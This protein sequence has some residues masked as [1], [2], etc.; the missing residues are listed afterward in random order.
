MAYSTFWEAY[1]AQ[2]PDSPYTPAG[3]TWTPQNLQN[4]A[5][6]YSDK[7][8]TWTPP[9]DQNA[10]LPNPIQPV[11]F[12]PYGDV[13]YTATASAVTNQGTHAQAYH[14]YQA[15]SGEQSFGYDASGNLITSGANYNPFS[16]AAVLQRN[17]DNTKRGSINSYAAQGQLYSGALKNKQST[18]AYNFDVSDDRLKRAAQ[19]YFHGND[20]TLTQ[21]QDQGAFTLAGALGPAWQ[22]FLASQQKGY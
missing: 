20:Y 7:N 12:D 5:N 16:Q 10:A 9:P 4:L 15:G 11:K 22:N 19:D 1:L 8:P 3:Q 21:V 17:Y 2:H 14:D 13:G 6:A 18:D